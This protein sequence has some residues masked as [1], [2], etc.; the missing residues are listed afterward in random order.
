M[1]FLRN[2]LTTVRLRLMLVAVLAILPILGLTLYAGYEQQ[3]QAIADAQQSALTIARMAALDQGRLIEGTRQL[4]LAISRFPAVQQHDSQACSEFLADLL[5]QNPL[6]SNLAAATPDGDVFCSA[7]PLSKKVNGSDR[8]FFQTA[9]KTGDFVVGNYIIMRGTGKPGIAAV[10]PALDSS[11]QVRAVAFAAV[12]LTWLDQCAIQAQ[13]PG[14]STLSV[15]DHDGTILSRYPDPEQWRG[16]SL[17]KGQAKFLLAQ[18]NGLTEAEGLDGVQRLYAFTRISGLSEG[19]LYVRAGIPKAAAL[20]DAQR[21]L[22][23]NLIALLG[24]T[25]LAFALA[26]LEGHTTVLRPLNTILQAVRR[27]DAGDLAARVGRVPRSRELDD[28]ARAFDQMA[29]TIQSRDLELRR[30]SARAEA[31]VAVAA[32]LNSDLDLNKV[33]RVVCQ[34]AVRALQVRGACVGL[35]DEQ[36]DSLRLAAPCGLTQCVCGRVQKSLEETLSQSLK[37]GQQVLVTDIGMPAELQYACRSA[38]EGGMS[39]VLGAP[40]IHEGHL[41][42]VIWVC[43]PEEI[44]AFAEE[45]A[46]FLKAISDMAARAVK[47]AGLYRSLRREE[48]RRAELVRGLISAQEDE[49]KR[50]A[51]E[52]HDE[53]SQGLTAL[54]VGLESAD[55]ALVSGSGE[56]SNQLQKTKAIA[57]KMLL[58][59]R[60]LVGDLRP[61]L[62][63][64]LGL[65]PAIAW[66]GK[67]RLAPLGI[68][69]D[70]KCDATETRLPPEYETALFRIAQEAITNVVKHSQASK[71]SVDLHASNS[72]LVL[73]V[74]DN[75]RGFVCPDDAAPNGSTGSF[76]LQG[77]QERVSILGGKFSIQTAPGK[78]TILEAHVPLAS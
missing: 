44:T 63:D 17:P 6:Y 4:L 71:V 49:R 22:R 47:N 74:T 52:L 15:V 9:L 66:Y 2:F 46:K 8:S 55:M 57:R 32:R 62:L 20:A 70:L 67:Q 59:T 51:R 3:Q 50:I 27:L 35:Y 19:D 34:E 77:M 42:G 33:L 16:R 69:L 76:G 75:G 39:A 73:K 64:D 53:T 56:A 37:R 29:G 5:A 10:Y 12:D 72:Q 68:D 54:M 14:G 24:A 41:I 65:V 78:G 38:K 7:V 25:V 26:G 61:S 36:D 18:A 1:A 40:M 31:L 58:N 45:D 43:M 11:G 48:R 28:L 13:P 30:E 21:L 23:R 60:R